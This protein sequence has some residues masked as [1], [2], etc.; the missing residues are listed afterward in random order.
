MVC[1]AD[2]VRENVPQSD[3]CVFHPHTL[4]LHK[5]CLEYRTAVSTGREGG[6]NRSNDRFKVNSCKKFLRS[7]LFSVLKMVRLFP[8]LMVPPI[9]PGLCSGISITCKGSTTQYEFNTHFNSCTLIVLY[10]LESLPQDALIL[11]RIQWSWHLSERKK[12]HALNYVSM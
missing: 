8:S 5:A 2:T 11:G 12:R 1:A 7:T 4:H 9:C 10:M 6:S 3:V